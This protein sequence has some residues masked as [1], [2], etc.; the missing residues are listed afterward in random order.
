[1]HNLAEDVSET[2]C[3]SKGRHISEVFSLFLLSYRLVLQDF[4]LSECENTTLISNM[5]ISLVLRILI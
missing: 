1:V 4:S 3:R 5:I 2:S